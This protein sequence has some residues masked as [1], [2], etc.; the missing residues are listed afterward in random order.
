MGM[1]DLIRSSYD[2]GEQFTNV[3]CHTKDIE[4]GIGGTMTDYWIDPAGQLWYSSYIG[5]HTFEEYGELHPEYNSERK[6]LNFRWIPTGEHGRF[7]PCEITKY[8]EIYPAEW[9]GKW[10]DW[11]RL[12]LHFRYGILQEHI[13]ITGR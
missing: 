2:L 9:E 3:V 11:P 10:E 4:D 8:I 12:Q 5:T 13:D 1:F 7:K 6:W